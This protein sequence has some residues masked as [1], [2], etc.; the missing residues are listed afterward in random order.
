MLFD[1]IDTIQ[2]LAQGDFYKNR[3]SEFFICQNFQCTV[4]NM[5]ATDYMD[6]IFWSDNNEGFKLPV[7]K[8]I[9]NEVLSFDNV[10]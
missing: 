9:S 10:K 1:N 3:K 7:L 5:Q 8:R 4:I 2:K 6:S